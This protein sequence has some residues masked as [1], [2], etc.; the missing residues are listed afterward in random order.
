MRLIVTLAATPQAIVIA[1]RRTSNFRVFPSHRDA[2]RLHR[3]DLTANR[4]WQT[5]PK[6]REDAIGRSLV[7]FS[8]STLLFESI[9]HGAGADR[10]MPKPDADGGKD[11]IADGGGNDRRRRLAEA[12]WSL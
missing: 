2:R 12:D 5:E 4:A 7:I 11:R 9:A 1:T 3:S 6:L 8:G 10:Q